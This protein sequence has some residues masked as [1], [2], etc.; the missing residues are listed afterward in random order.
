MWFISK[1]KIFAFYIIV[2]LTVMFWVSV[3]FGSNIVFSSKVTYKLLSDNI[4]LDS[5]S[6]K[7]NLIVFNSISDISKYK[8]E[9]GCDLDSNYVWR[10]G[11]DYYFTII[12]DKWNSCLNPN[13]YLKTDWQI[14]FWSHIKFNIYSDFDIFNLYSDLN[15]NS[16]TILKNKLEKEIND[17]AL[18]KK[19]NTLD[20]VSLDRKNQENRYKLKIINDILESRGQKYLIPVLNHELSTN[21]SKIPN[22]RRPYRENYTDWIHQSWDIDTTFWEEV[23]ALD[24]WI[25]VRVVNNWQWSDFSKLK[26]TNLSYED[27]LQN[28]DILRWNQVWLK[29]SKWDVV[30]YW[31]LDKVNEEVKQWMLVSRWT[32]FW[33]VWRTWVP[34][35]NYTDYHLDFSIQ[36]NPY[37]IKMA[38]K[39]DFLDYM[40]WDWYFKWENADFILKN[41]YKIFT[42]V[43]LW[44]KK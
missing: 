3:V 28:L 16:L 20:Y 17:F 40:K 13:I 12:Y 41:Q 14:V 10:K 30:F 6:L 5:Y 34:D 32:V 24:N 31:H 36:K 42:W 39:Y 2:L 4:F 26:Y 23:V 29:T 22:A 18:I 1:Y 8:L 33:T 9:T 21:L 35:K 38:G 44:Y 19:W 37:N 25:I 27:K 7:N 43:E 11:N 15:T